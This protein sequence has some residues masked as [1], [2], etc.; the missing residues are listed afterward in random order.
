V[1]TDVADDR[2]PRAARQ[3]S[4]KISSASPTKVKVLTVS[5]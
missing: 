4:Q 1:T 5:P 2:D 3:K